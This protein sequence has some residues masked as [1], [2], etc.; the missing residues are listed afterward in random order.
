MIFRLFF[1]ENLA[2]S[3][4]SLLERYG[5]VKFDMCI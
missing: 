3:L 4:L 5:V 2:Q 1:V